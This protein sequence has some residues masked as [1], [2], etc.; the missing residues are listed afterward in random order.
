MSVTLLISALKASNEKLIETMKVTDDAVLIN[1]C[2]NEATGEIKTSNGIVKVVETTTR[3]VGISR[4]LALDNAF[5]DVVL[6]ADD[7]IVYKDGYA[8]LI[9]REFDAHPEAD[10]IFFNFEVD[11][12][13]KTYYNTGFARVTWRNSGRFPTFALAMRL[14]SIQRKNLRFSPLFGG[15]AKYSCGED[16]L[17]IKDALKSGLKL[18]TSPTVLG[19]EVPRPSTWFNGYTDKFFK[20]RGVLY[21]YLYG[22]LATPLAIRFWLRHKQEMCKNISSKA[23]LKLILSGIKEGRRVKKGKNEF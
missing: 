12:A 22:A 11:E 7:D 19:T 3:G 23:A 15:G 13:R 1:Q 18:Y 20:D 14:S 2:D 16:S 9:Q 17:F 21:T 8:S 10:G 6:F 4:N 5:G